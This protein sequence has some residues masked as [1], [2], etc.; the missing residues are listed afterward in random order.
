LRQPD[1]S[2][3][4]GYGLEMGPYLAHDGVCDRPMRSAETRAWNERTSAE[5]LA[6]VDTPGKNAPPT[7][8][9]AMA[10]R[11]DFEKLLNPAAA[12]QKMDAAC[13]ASFQIPS[14]NLMRRR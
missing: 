2:K 12:A 5:V 3:V 4:V 14:K 9:T 7:L 8:S 1:D 10:F 11:R 13:A 6:L